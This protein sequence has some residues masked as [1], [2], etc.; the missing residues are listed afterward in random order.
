MAKKE[1]VSGTFSDLV[2]GD[3]KPAKE[4]KKS[5]DYRPI[6]V[7][8]SHEIIAKLDDIAAAIE[9]SRSEV[10]RYAI[11]DLIRRY[12]SGEIRPVTETRTETVKMLKQDN[13]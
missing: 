12:D 13:K 4:K 7:A 9:Q 11:D 6:G 8:L 5:D 10:I 1:Q 2:G 3:K